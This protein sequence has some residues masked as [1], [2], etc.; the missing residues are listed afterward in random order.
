[1]VRRPPRPDYSRRAQ[2]LPPWLQTG[3]IEGRRQTRP[4][5]TPLP[6]GDAFKGSSSGMGSSGGGA[7]TPV[8]LADPH[9]DP[10]QS[11]LATIQH[12]R[13]AEQKKWDQPR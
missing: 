6:T 3:A 4:G 9:P 13:N 1:M 5:E 12:S 7:G 8:L 11:N 10:T 2:F